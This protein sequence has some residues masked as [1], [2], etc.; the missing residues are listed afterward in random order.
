MAKHKDIPLENWITPKQTA[1]Q[2]GIT[3]RHVLNLCK[4]GKVECR[5][6]VDRWLVNPQSAAEWKPQRRRKPKE[7]KQ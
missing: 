5:K 1:E 6:V 3:E 7:P 2:L 4:S